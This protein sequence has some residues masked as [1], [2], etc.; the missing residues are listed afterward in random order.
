MRVTHGC[1]QLYPEHIAALYAMT[2]LGTQVHIVNQPYLAGQRDGVVFFEAHAP[3]EDYGGDDVVSRRQTVS[4]QSDQAAIDWAR[5][6]EYARLRPGYPL[7]V[8]AGSPPLPAVVASAP[9]VTAPA[10]EPVAGTAPRPGWYVQAGSFQDPDN[11]R[12][13]VAMLG[14][15]GPPIPARSVVVQDNHRVLAGPYASRQEAETG[16]ARIRAELKLQAFPL[17]IGASTG[18][19]QTRRSS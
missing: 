16:A 4:R 5:V 10:S 3:L 7:P 15:L 1:L 14:L 13:V 2:A 6:D 18:Q 17:S 19:R 8:T 12:R 11:A 9:V